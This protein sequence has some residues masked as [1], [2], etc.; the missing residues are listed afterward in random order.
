LRSVLVTGAAG[1]VGKAVVSDLL[2]R[3]YTVRAAS[4][5]KLPGRCGVEN[6]QMPELAH[7]P[8]WT[9]LLAG[10]EAV[11]HT[12]AIAHTNG[13]DESTYDAVNH[14]A[15]V[16]LAQAAKGRVERLVFLSSI[17]A[18]C[19]PAIDR[20]LSEADDPHPVDAYGR[21]KLLA[22][23]GLARL[24]ANVVTL[25]PVLVAAPR[26]SGN[27]GTMLRFAKLPLPLPFGGLTA[28]RSVVARADLCTAI[29]HVL[30]GRVHI[31]QTYIVAH[32]KPFEIASMFAALREGLARPRHLIAIPVPLIRY[33]AVIA[34]MEPT[35]GRLLGDLVASP[36]KLMATGWVPHISPRE[37]LIDIGATR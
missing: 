7:R 37:A 17:R 10:V 14:Q 5:R 12:A 23:E 15:V 25:R 19:G 32:P 6:V 34:R 27:L 21:S 26:P 18:Q 3:G 31:G 8:N 13:L 28:R 22:E 16:A 30:N 29:E 36:L 20:I 35:A 4:R 2:A 24:G 33:V 11:I 1:F 9:P